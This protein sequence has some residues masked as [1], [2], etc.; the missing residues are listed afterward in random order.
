MNSKKYNGWTNYAT[1]RV[2]LEHIDGMNLKDFYDTKPEIHDVA[3]WL[4]ERVLDTVYDSS[5]EGFVRDYC[6]AFLDD[7]NWFEIAEHLIEDA[8]YD[9]SIIEEVT[10]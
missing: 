8:N 9:T 2:N 4:K 6:L 3:Q 5:E 10:D 1:W 7:V